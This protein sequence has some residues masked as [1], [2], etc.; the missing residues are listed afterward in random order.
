MTIDVQND[1]LGFDNTEAVTVTLRRPD[2][3]TPL[4]VT[5]ALRRTV[6]LRSE[7]YGGVRLRGDEIVWNL[8]NSQL[9]GEELRPGDAIADG[10]G[11]RWT[12]LSVGR[13]TFGARWRAVC[14]K[15]R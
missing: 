6:D 3:E 13:L 15:E 8:P 7:T 5:H 11:T 4:A 9:A 2:G 12:V 10:S 14:R 1:V